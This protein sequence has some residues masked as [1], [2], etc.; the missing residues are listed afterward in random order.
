[1]K[2][3]MKWL[4]LTAVATFCITGIA[5]ADHR[6]YDHDSSIMVNNYYSG[7]K[8][9]RGSGGHGHNHSGG[10]SGGSTTPPATTTPAITP[11]PGTQ[12]FA[13]NDLGMHCAD[14][15]F[16]IFTLLPPF[17]N[18]NAQLV[19]NS[20]LVSTG[21]TLTY[22]ALAD[23][24][25]SINTSSQNK[26]NFW[27]FV[28][29]LFGS[30][31]LP[32][33]GLTG[34]TMAS[35]NPAS[36]LW[37]T[38]YNWFEA[39]GIP[40][41]PLD[42]NMNTNNYPMVR[43][44]ASDSFGQAI[45]TSD[46]V[47]PISSEINCGVCHSSNTG[48]LNAEPPSGW[49]NLAIGSDVDWRMNVL[50]LHDELNNYVGNL[51]ASAIAGSPVLCDSCH[52]SNALAVWG[53]VGKT[54]V[55]NMTA[56]M[57]SVHAAV[58]LPGSSST[59]DEDGTRDACYNCHPG[60]DTQ[61]L[62]GAMG[63]PI[64]TSGNHE[65]ECQ[66]CHGSMADV[67]RNARNGW[68]DVPKCQSCHHDGVREISAINTDGSAKV[69]AD[70][71]FAS[72]DNVP[73]AGTSLYR[74]S[75]GHGDLQCAACHNSPHAE[76]TDI[77]S[78]NGS[79]I[80]D[81]KR[82]IDAQGYAAAIRE[83]TVCHA[84]TPSTVKGGPHGMHPVGQTWVSAHHNDSTFR[85]EPK[86]ECFYCHGSSSTGSSLAVVKVDKVLAGRTFKAGTRVTCWSCHSG[87]NSD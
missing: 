80:N 84:S 75:V 6:S 41:T 85:T 25:G 12:L 87:P 16:S 21:Y 55:S 37:N 72:N 23:S 50:R 10:G 39:T 19:V 71:R 60:R 63:N 65:M 69:W 82:A 64:D 40:I 67:G 4:L 76:F 34:F 33:V 53:I 45:A 70:S 59:L 7:E 57:H 48:N 32:E 61:C 14:S 77:P 5:S 24:T 74:F 68:F 27:E 81:F 47:L 73:E 3:K 17:N 52:N 36:L 35:H 20:K 62:R 83:C 30:S 43:V 79:E 15:D 28:Q 38:T 26:T 29:P 2:R 44:V 66:S 78:G 42:D 11:A 18:L 49:V 1:M 54:D 58:S 46:T 13:W 9:K 51:E 31:P 22:E 8:I 86:S 56:A